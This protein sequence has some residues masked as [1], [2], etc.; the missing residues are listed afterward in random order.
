M[1]ILALYPHLKGSHGQVRVQL[2]QQ[3]LDKLCAAVASELPR[4]V[5]RV[6]IAPSGT[7]RFR[8]FAELSSDLFTWFGQLFLNVLGENGLEIQ[9]DQTTSVPGTPFQGR[10]MTTLVGQGVV[11]RIVSLIN[12]QLGAGDVLRVSSELFGETRVTLDP[13][14]L[15]R[16]Y[17]PAGVGGHLTLVQWQTTQD[18]F[19]IDFNWWHAG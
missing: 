17:A 9:I 19:F 14:P 4:Q 10:L 5:K 6:R 13:F 8:I 11:S 7:N 3:M 2:R 1:D 12:G 16:K 15:L 18:S